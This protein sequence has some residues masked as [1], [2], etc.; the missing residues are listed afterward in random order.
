MS[1][2]LRIAIVVNWNNPFEQSVQLGVSE[3]LPNQIGI[4]P[5][6][7]QAVAILQ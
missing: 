5:Q 6:V 3:T 1:R 7:E 4:L 2:W